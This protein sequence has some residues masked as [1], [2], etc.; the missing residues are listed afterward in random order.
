M[1]GCSTVEDAGGA[2][3]TLRMG[4]AGLLGGG[5]T[6]VLAAAI[7]TGGAGVWATGMRAATG[8]AVDALVSLLPTI[9]PC[10]TIAET[11]SF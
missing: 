10:A 6:A 1:A 3:L 4:S 9:V 8:R 11:A 2:G 7:A 5:A